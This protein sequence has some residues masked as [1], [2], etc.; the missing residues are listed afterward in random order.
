[1]VD[2]SKWDKTGQVDLVFVQILSVLSKASKMIRK[3]NNL[4][5][6]E[7]VCISFGMLLYITL[8]TLY[9]PKTSLLTT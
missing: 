3:R 9:T 5:L 6:L 4:K 8:S 2:R 1:M 7:V